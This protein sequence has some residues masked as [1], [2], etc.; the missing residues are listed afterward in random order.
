[1]LKVEAVNFK[2]CSQSIKVILK[3]NTDSTPKTMTG[4]ADWKTLVE[5]IRNLA[6]NWDIDIA[7]QLE[8]YLEEVESLQVS[9]DGGSTNLNFAEAALLIQSSTAIYSKKVEYLHQLVIQSLECITTKRTDPNRTFK[10]ITK[11]GIANVSLLAEEAQSFGQES[12]FLLLDDILEI[13][14]NIDLDSAGS[15]FI[16]NSFHQ[17]SR[18]SV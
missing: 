14:E 18:N 15:S 16:N 8:A 5:P 4:I 6:A 13:G 1:M 11:S 17:R 2:H 3:L 12:S 7:D 10:S 9:F